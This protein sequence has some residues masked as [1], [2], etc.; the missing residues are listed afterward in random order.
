MRACSKKRELHFLKERGFQGGEGGQ[1]RKASLEEE[2]ESL[3]GAWTIVSPAGPG[4]PWFPLSCPAKLE[5]RKKVGR[6]RVRQ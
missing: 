6:Q 4:K 1:A 3:S 2:G 5:M